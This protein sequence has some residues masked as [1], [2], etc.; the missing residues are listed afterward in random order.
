M[1][2]RAE[3]RDQFAD[4][5]AGMNVIPG[6]GIDFTS[7]ARTLVIVLALYLLSSA[8][9]WVAAYGL[10]EIVQRTVRDMRAS[11]E[12]KIH[13]L[14]LRYFDTHSRG[15]LL[16]RV[17]NDIDNV[18][19]G[20]QESIS[21]LVLAVFTLLGLVVMMFWISPLLAVIA[22]LLVPAAAVVTILVAKRSRK[23]FVAQWDATGTLNGQI[24][25]SFTGHELITAY[26]RT[27]EI[28]R[29]FTETN[30]SLFHAAYRAQ[31]VSGLV[32][33]LVTF[34]SNIGYVVVAVIGGLRVASGTSTLGEI[35]AMI[36]YSRQLSQPL[37]RSV[38]CSICCSPPR[39]PRRECS[40]SSTRRSR[41]P[42][43][44]PP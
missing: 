14:P 37:A 36:Q 38:R 6:A 33:P 21:Q 25:E 23:H 28:E 39:H 20:M 29:R 44:R 41:I 24:E 27:A 40:R 3:G 16:S 43:L 32:L 9:I 18:S 17:T 7:L 31:F 35:Q 2:L 15:D 1:Q 8:L 42:S 5:V 4:M 11:V 34:L 22:L 13:R 19:T 26:G 10:N 30:D 12:R